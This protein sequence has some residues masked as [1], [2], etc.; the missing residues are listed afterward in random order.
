MEYCSSN[1]I[2]P[3]ENH[4]HSLPV[5][6]QLFHTSLQHC[7]SCRGTRKDKICSKEFVLTKSLSIFFSYTIWSSV[8][9]YGSLALPTKFALNL[10]Q[11]I[12]SIA[13]NQAFTRVN[14]PTD[15]YT[16]LLLQYY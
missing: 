13:L 12:S 16:Q 14:V 1:L 8:V 5:Y 9:W 7:S 3:L 6:A 2:F 4:L 10:F 15:S 11:N